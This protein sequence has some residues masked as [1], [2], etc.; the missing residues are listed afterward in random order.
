[1]APYG[2]GGEDGGSGAQVYG[3]ASPLGGDTVVEGT[4]ASERTFAGPNGVW[5]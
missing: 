1:M 3:M 4:R 5:M 2:A